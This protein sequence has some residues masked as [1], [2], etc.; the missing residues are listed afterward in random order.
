V[1]VLVDAVN[2]PR[3]HDHGDATAAEGSRLSGRTRGN[4]LVHLAG[5]E[6][7]VGREVLVRVDHAGPYAL[8]GALVV[9]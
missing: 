5:D 2:P 4:K 9:A 1:E 8:R 3:G 7:L 6:A